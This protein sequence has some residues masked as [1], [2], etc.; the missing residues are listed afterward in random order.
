MRDFGVKALQQ[1]GEIA[2]NHP[3]LADTARH[4]LSQV[5]DSV[6]TILCIYPEMIMVTCVLVQAGLPPPSTPTGSRA[7]SVASMSSARSS[8]SR[9]STALSARYG[10]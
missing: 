10:R 8:L 4:L 7:S 1:L 6:Q 2:A 3:H 5:H 9:G